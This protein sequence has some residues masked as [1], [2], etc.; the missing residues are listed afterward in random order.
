MTQSLQDTIDRLEAQAQP[1]R[2]L[3]EYVTG[4]EAI[5]LTYLTGEL[6]RLYAE[7]RQAHQQA[8]EHP[9]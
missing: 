3:G 2:E 9:A 1:L 7:L 4:R 6:N 5:E 8:P